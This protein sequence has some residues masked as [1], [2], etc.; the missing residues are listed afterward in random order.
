MSFEFNTKIW[1]C[2]SCFFPFHF[3]SHSF[4]LPFYKV[5]VHDKLEIKHVSFPT[6][7]RSLLCE[8]LVLGEHLGKNV[9]PQKATSTRGQGTGWISGDRDTG[10]TMGTGHRV[11]VSLCCTRERGS[12]EYLIVNL[13]SKSVL[14]R[15]YLLV[16]S[17]L[18]RF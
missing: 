14:G 18:R 15:I 8:Q 12:V 2:M 1:A 5:P 10:W 3:S 6:E 16:A 13:L 9:W 17:T 11:S 4:L 7:F